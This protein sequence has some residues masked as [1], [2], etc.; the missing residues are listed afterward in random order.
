MHEQVPEEL[1]RAS[2]YDDIP[3]HKIQG[4]LRMGVRGLNRLFAKLP[5]LVNISIGIFINPRDHPVCLEP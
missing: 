1:V 2:E 3:R 5:T 4:K